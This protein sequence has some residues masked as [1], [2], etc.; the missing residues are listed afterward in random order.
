VLNWDT[1]NTKL[2]E[3]LQKLRTKQIMICN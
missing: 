3:I 1:G 2:S